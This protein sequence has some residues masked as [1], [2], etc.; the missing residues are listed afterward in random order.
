MKYALSMLSILIFSV[1]V[2]AQNNNC[3]V[4]ERTAVSE[5]WASCADLAEG[6]ACYGN[7]SL[8][9][10]LL[11]DDMSFA[12]SG[13]RVSLDAVTRISSSVGDNGYGVA[14]LRTSGYTIDSWQAQDVSLVLLGDVTIA[15]T[16]NENINVPVVTT[17]IVGSQGANIRS[18]ASSDYRIITS[19]FEGETVKLTGRW[20]DNS[21]YRVQLI[22]GETG[23]IAAGAVAEDVSHL[24]VVDINSPAP[25]LLY[26]PYA[27][28][29]LETAMTDAQC[30]ESWES[31]IL[32]QSSE[33]IV[34]RLRINQGSLLL[35]G[36]IFVQSRP[37]VDL[38]IF[39]IEGTVQFEDTIA[40]AGFWLRIPLQ[41]GSSVIET[42][43][44][45]RVAYLP[46]EILPRY[47]YI[48]IDLNTIITPAPSENRS[49]IVDTLV[50]AP[51]VLTTGEGGANLRS[52]PSRT[53]PIRGVLAFRETAN[54][55]GRTTGADGNMWWE[56]A[57]NVWINGAVVVTGGDCIAV[58]QSQRIPILPPT[59]TPER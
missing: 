6:Q 33:A 31:G 7:P 5:S 59:A 20:A 10:E 23:W 38:R 58:P 37:T 32:V 19:L 52:G 29:S 34:I 47:V 15:N 46:T 11:S 26:A 56:L 4:L 2:S 51:C 14:M 27:S 25:E 35:K 18:G 21:Y 24:A 40:Q 22:S 41:E 28:F 43:E 13:D 36:T 55:I 57:Q 49:P 3:P 12:S 39:V 1:A 53:F 54:P 17:Q 8:S 50:T 9:A 42:Y 44:L 16:G 30:I 45:S 48:G